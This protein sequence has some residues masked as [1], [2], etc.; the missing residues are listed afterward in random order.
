MCPKRW[1]GT[2]VADQ[3]SRVETCVFIDLSDRTE[4]GGGREGEFGVGG[5]DPVR[6]CMRSEQKKHNREN[7]ARRLCNSSRSCLPFLD[8][9][10]L[11]L[12]DQSQSGLSFYIV[13]LAGKTY[14]MT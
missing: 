14:L 12:F 4:V 11:P 8:N 1:R 2:C 7:S 3:A 10:R 9:A 6:P 5:A 13:R